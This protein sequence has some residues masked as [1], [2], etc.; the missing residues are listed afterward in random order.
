MEELVQEQTENTEETHTDS[1]A[2]YNDTDQ[3]E[4]QPS[5]EEER[6]ER[7]RRN[8]AALRERKE[9]AERERDELLRRMKEY[10]TRSKQKEDPEEDDIGVGEEDLVEGKHIRK[11]SK[12]L[13]TLKNQLNEQAYQSKNMAT[14]ARLKAQYADF[15][16]VV[17]K[18]NIENL[19]QNYPE[20]AKTLASSGD[21]Y[22]AGV[23][24]YTII[25]NLGLG[26]PDIY[27]KDRQK[28]QANSSKPRPLASVSPQQG[29][30]P[31]SHANA[32]ANGLTK[33]LQEQLLKEM[34][35]A[36]KGY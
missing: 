15:D 29:D 3:Q 34:A 17:S 12:E 19:K 30:S 13:R 11:M 36:R 18:D 28:A 8:V 27:E 2:D 23:S 10:E 20:I 32:F 7:E 9:Q 26:T 22:S 6:R 35:Q 31:L 5:P 1:P 21:L 33:E 25:K 4:S 24:A 14:E 16:A